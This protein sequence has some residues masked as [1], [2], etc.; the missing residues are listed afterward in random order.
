[1][2]TLMRGNFWVDIDRN[3]LKD[4]NLEETDVI[5]DFKEYAK[6][7]NI[8]LFEIEYIP[9]DKYVCFYTINSGTRSDCRSYRDILKEL[10][11]PLGK[12]KSIGET[13]ERVK[14]L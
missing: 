14:E 5:F 13:F 7:N 6:S 1:M 9:N 2:T 10:L 12:V 3:K 4:K 8:Q 11:M